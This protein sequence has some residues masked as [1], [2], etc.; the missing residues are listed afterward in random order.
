[1]QLSAISQHALAIYHALLS[2]K[3]L[4]SSLDSATATYGSHTLLKFK[5]TPLLVASGEPQLHR[6]SA[7]LCQHPPTPVPQHLM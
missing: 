4:P 3:V 6:A 1:M 5:G 7:T 2:S